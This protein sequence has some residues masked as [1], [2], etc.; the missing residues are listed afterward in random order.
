MDVP[1]AMIG[2][3]IAVTG[4]AITTTA[5]TYT[6]DSYVALYN[7]YHCISPDFYKDGQ[8]A[9]NGDNIVINIYQICLKN[10]K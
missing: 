10:F 2:A 6:A 3:N 7:T 8:L 4:A 1:I 5:A 9:I